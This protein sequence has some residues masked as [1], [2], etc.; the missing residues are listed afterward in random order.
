MIYVTQ[1]QVDM[2]AAAINECDRMMVAEDCRNDIERC[3]SRSNDS[4]R[5]RHYRYRRDAIRDHRKNL[6]RLYE[7]ITHRNPWKDIAP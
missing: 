3:D 6:V 4:I 7:A 1:A 5:L 2:L